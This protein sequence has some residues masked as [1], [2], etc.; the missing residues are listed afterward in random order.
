MATC[1]MQRTHD[2][3]SQT[4]KVH[5]TPGLCCA[6]LVLPNLVM[7]ESCN[8]HGVYD[9]NVVPGVGAAGA[10]GLAGCPGQL[11]W[12]TLRPCGVEHGV[13]VRGSERPPNGEWRRQTPLQ[14]DLRAE[15]RA[16]E[17]VRV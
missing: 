3:Y 14:T 5:K 6:T 12:C 11:A 9:S 17:E 13:L 2:K 7:H 1:D 8:G 10:A 15:D 16:C 4:L